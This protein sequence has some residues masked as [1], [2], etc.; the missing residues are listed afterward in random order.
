VVRVFFA[1]IFN[2]QQSTSLLMSDADNCHVVDNNNDA[3]SSFS[4]DSGRG[5]WEGKYAT[6]SSCI[7]PVHMF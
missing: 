4:E 1:G 5:Q 6:F 2:I 3:L 7:L